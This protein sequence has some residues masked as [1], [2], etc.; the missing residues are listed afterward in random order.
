MKLGRKVFGTLLA[1]FACLQAGV[2][3]AHASLLGSTATFQYYAFGG[4][5]TYPGS[6]NTFTVSIVHH[7]NGLVLF[8]QIHYFRQRS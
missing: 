4:P 3:Q 7:N 8:G 2:G 1:A 6:Q 5:F